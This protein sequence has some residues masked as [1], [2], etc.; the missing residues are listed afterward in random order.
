MFKFLFIIFAFFILL[1]F[2]LGFSIFRTFK[3]IFFGRGNT[4]KQN[5]YYQQRQQ[6]S[7]ASQRRD[8]TSQ[9]NNSSQDNRKKIFTKDEGEYVDY[10]E[11]K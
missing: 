9:Q 5:P 11:I 1:L 6:Q 7:N 3:N 8:A 10:E 2:L 4:S